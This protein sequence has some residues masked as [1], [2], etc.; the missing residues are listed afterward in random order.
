[1]GLQ[2]KIEDLLLEYE[3]APPEDYLYNY[4]LEDRKYWMEYSESE[5]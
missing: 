2:K 3:G 4:P 1:M 5:D